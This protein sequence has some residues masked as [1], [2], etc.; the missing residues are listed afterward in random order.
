MKT[1]RFVRWHHSLPFGSEIALS[2]RMSA[3]SCAGSSRRTKVAFQPSP[4]HLLNAFT[5]PLSACHETPVQILPI[6]TDLS[7]SPLPLVPLCFVAFPFFF[8]SQYMLLPF[9]LFCV[10]R[11]LPLLGLETHSLRACLSLGPSSNHVLSLSTA[12]AHTYTHT[13]IT[14]THA[15]A[16]AHAHMRKSI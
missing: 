14:Y 11:H 8:S 1:A 13:H 12:N 2:A 16:R 3:P 6:Q 7:W 15:R 10:N 9:C 4:I 5:A